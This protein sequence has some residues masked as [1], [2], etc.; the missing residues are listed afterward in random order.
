MSIQVFRYQG[1]GILYFLVGAIT[2]I[3][4]LFLLFLGN[5]LG[6][7][8]IKLFSVIGASLGATEGIQCIWYSFVA[9]AIL[10]IFLLFFRSNFLSRIQ[11]FIQ[12]I[13]TCFIGKSIRTYCAQEGRDKSTFHFTTAIFAG[14]LSLGIKQL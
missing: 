3:L 8:D 9:G 2:P 1:W 7:G 5:V 10:A 13:K 14:F 4:I 11:Y 6:A 12:Y